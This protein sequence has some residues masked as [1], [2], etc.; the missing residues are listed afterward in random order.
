M[1]NSVLAI[2]LIFPDPKGLLFYC[3]G[4]EVVIL[5]L[6]HVAI[7]FWKV[8]FPF[9]AKRFESNGYIRYIHA[10]TIFAVCVMPLGTL[11]A[12]LGSGG[13]TI[14]RFP[15]VACYARS[16]AATFYSFILPISIAMAVGV[17]LIAIILWVIVVRVGAWQKPSKVR[18]SSCL[19]AVRIILSIIFRTNMYLYDQISKVIR[20][21]S[22]DMQ[23]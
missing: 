18:Y 14:S 15:P 11:G 7:L 4:L 16:N 20:S 21:I 8:K 10:M 12:V 5:W 1:S 6:C 9:H 19:I 2:I 3:N 23:D 17:S 22:I 13:F